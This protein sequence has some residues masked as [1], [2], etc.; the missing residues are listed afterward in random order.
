MWSIECSYSADPVCFPQNASRG[1]GK[2]AFSASFGRPSL[3]AEEAL[4]TKPYCRGS[5]MSQCARA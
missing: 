2:M 1:Y 4:F 3:S 5:T